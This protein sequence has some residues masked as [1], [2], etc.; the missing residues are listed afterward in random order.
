MG[1]SATATALVTVVPEGTTAAPQR[2]R[3]SAVSSE[4]DA[5]ASYNVL[6]D[7]DSPTGDDL[8]LVSA[9]T[10]SSDVVSF[11]PD[12][13]ITD[14]NTGSGEGTGSSVQF[15][16]SDGVEQ[17][18][19]TLTVSISAP[20]STTPVIYPSFTSAV[21][22]AVAVAN[23][24]RGVVSA[25]ADPVIIGNVQAQ[26][27]SEAATARLD[28]QDG[29]VAVTATDPG[30]YYF[31]FEASSGGHAVTG[32]LRADF[33][34]PNDSSRSVV[35]MTD[36]AYLAPGAQTVVD[37]LA[38][39]T[40]PDGQGLAV[41]QVDLPADAPI[42]AAVVDLH[43]IQVSATHTPR[44]TVFDYSVFDGAGTRTG[45]IRIV[46]IPAQRQIPPPLASPITASVRAGDAVTIPI[47][48]FAT[49]Q[50]GSPVTAELDSAQVAALPGRAFST[51]D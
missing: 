42:T 14:R 15:V 4:L 25:A 40:D 17:T 22:G 24:L 3:R 32:V 9:T 1:A 27:G 35:L 28:P 50:D 10:D 19:G 21:V 23:P 49:S 43:L 45:Q 51:G 44:A 37:P 46:P 29:S 34:P 12:G 5:T 13:T 36:V 16:V 2:V 47:A 26:A 48:R 38:N 41:Q 18:P 11:R 20:H 31:T 33:V 39:D 8:Y 6:D 7:F 30:T